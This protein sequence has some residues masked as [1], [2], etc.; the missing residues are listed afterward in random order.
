MDAGQE[1]QDLWQEYEQGATEEA[2]LLKDID[3][4]S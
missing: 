3:K 1:L 2:Q 4:V